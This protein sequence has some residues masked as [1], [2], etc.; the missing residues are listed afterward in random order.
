MHPVRK[1]VALFIVLSLLSFSFTACVTYH[2]EG[3]AA[4]GA[5][6][7]AAGALLDRHNPW[8]GG[9]IGAALGAAFGATLA[10]ISVCGTREAL[11]SG[12]PVQ[13]MTTDGRSRYMAEPLGY[14]SRRHCRKIRERAWQD[15]RLAKDETREIC[16]SEKI[17]R[18]HYS[19][20]RRFEDDR[21]ETDRNGPPPWAPAHGVRAKQRY[22]YYPSS[23]V[24]FSEERGMYAYLSDGRWQEARR[25]PAAIRLDEDYVIVE[26]DGDKPY[27]YHDDIVS[28]YPPHKTKDKKKKKKDR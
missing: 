15:G 16:E 12:K 20:N 26:L 7:G 17:E 8:R 14:D 18:G 2:Y 4:G 11:D 19:D 25:L 21:A 28:K 1:T 27:L 6:G 5:V 22:R 13:Y 10:D 23:Y 3:A 9:V 24:Y